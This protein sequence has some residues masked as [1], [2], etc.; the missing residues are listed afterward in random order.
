MRARG[1]R[2]KKSIFEPDAVAEI[3]HHSRGIPRLIQNI[4]LDA[5]L[6]AMAADKKTIDAE[7][8]GQAIVDMDAV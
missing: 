4:A 2:K 1:S 7:A 8:V 3:F 6:A 5:M